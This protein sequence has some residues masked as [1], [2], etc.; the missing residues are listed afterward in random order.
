[1]D[2]FNWNLMFQPTI[3][4]LPIVGL[5]PRH[6]SY[7]SDLYTLYAVICISFFMYT[8]TFLQTINIFI[9]EMDLKALAAT[10][11]VG[12]HI[13]AVLKVS[14]LLQNLKEIKNLM[15]QLNSESFQPKSTSQLKMVKE[16]L[17][18][19]R[20]FYLTYQWGVLALGIFW[21]T[22]PILE[23]SYKDYEL[24]FFAWYPVDVKTSPFYQIVY[25]YQCVALFYIALAHMQLDLLSTGLMVYIGIQCDILCDN[26]THVTCIPD[27]VECIIHHKKILR[28]SR[29]FNAFI[30]NIILA[31]FVSSAVSIALGLFKLGLTVPGS[32]EFYTIITFAWIMILELFLYCWFGNEVELKSSN[33]PAAAC[34][35][36]WI[37]KS[38]K[39][40]KMVLFF[41]MRTQRHMTINAH[42]LFSLTLRTYMGIM[43]SSWSYFAV[44]RQMNAPQV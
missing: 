27:L 20:I 7:Q 21:L 3:F 13:V 17:R 35:C 25:L 9:V 37:G 28:F 44:L 23:K 42:N 11:F 12:E 16:Y 10:I 32:A 34:N 43:R 41:V 18:L 19:W 30:G 1:M 36:N 22:K 6:D 8:N 4:S 29:D 2:L 26:V 5:W 14:G 40:Q 31:Q 39:L 38:I 33:I 15:K 24:P